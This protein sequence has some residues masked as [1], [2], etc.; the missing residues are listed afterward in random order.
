MKQSK[1]KILGLIPA[2]GGSKGIKKKNIVPLA[3]KPLIFYTIKAAQGSSLLTDCI[4]STDDKEIADAAVGYGMKVP[5]LRPPE[6]SGDEARVQDVA[7][8]TLKEYCNGAFDYL[9]LLQP[10]APFRTSEDIDESIRLADQHNACS[11][12]SFTHVETYHP[13]YMYRLE[14]SGSPGLPSRVSQAFDYEVGMPR[15]QFPSMVYRNGA[16]YLTKTSY[17]REKESFVSENVVPYIMP[18]QRS[19]NID[20]IEDMQYAE[21]LISQKLKGK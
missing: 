20:T 7:F 17:L 11:V 15:Q 12:V 14:K 19:V 5:F 10:T 9:L 6:L 8:H 4:V 13:Y 2:R 3:G 18:P 16:I 21:F 1:L